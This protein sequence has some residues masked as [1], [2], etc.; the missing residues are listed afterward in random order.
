MG[1]TISKIGGNIKID[2]GSIAEYYPV[3][4]IA[5]RTEGNNLTI[6]HNDRQIRNIPYAQMTSP[7]GANVEEIANA[8]SVLLN[9][10]VSLPLTAFG[11]MQVAENTPQVQIRFPYN[12]LP[13]DTGQE[14]S[15]KAG[16]SV[17]FADAQASV[18]CSS[19]A[20]S[21]SQIRSTDTVRYGSGQGVEFMG[22]C[23]FTTG[24]ALSSQVFGLGDD[25]EGLYFGYNGAEF[26]VLRKSFGSLEIKE[27]TITAGE[28]TGAGNITITLDDTAVTVAI[29]EN[30]T[31]ADVCA[32]IV[33]ESAAFYNAGRGW[34]VHTDDNVTVEFISLVAENASGTFSFVDTDST[35]VTAGAFSEIVAGVAPT[36]TWV[37]QEDWN[38]DVMDGTGV[39]G[40]TL[41]PTKGN[42]YKI[43]YQ[44]LGYG[45]QD[46]FVE[47]SADGS[48]QLVHRF[49]YANSNTV[50][51]CLDPT[52]HLNMIAQTDTGYSGGALTMKTSSMAGFIQGKNGGY[53]IRRSATSIVTATTSEIVFLIVASRHDFNSRKNK[54]VV[55]PDFLNFANEGSKELTVNL[56]KNPTSILGAAALTDIQANV[57]VMK[58]GSTG[59]TVTG[60]SKLLTFTLAGGASEIVDLKKLDVLIRPND[61]FVF[62]QIGTSGGL[63]ANSIGLSWK[64]IY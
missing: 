41:D 12:I 24:V 57:S 22:T 53:G 6:K 34:E 3:D 27:I 25:D 58:Y 15:N 42:V 47:N 2:D 54:T 19:T 39:S 29:A 8:V 26:G 62:T 40:M 30:D 10:S 17:T 45:E 56:Y 49:K 61:R 16:S 52:F 20:E 46:F 37:A 14:L 13:P 36:D 5:L 50:P 48:F 43:Q 38:I 33:A 31:V 55:K 1:F 11:E 44:Y 28:S 32:A 64:E 35:G 60:G 18:T 63:G 4:D 23:V 9:D 7:S 51:W 59:T 21:F